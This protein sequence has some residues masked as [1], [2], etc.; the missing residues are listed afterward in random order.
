LQKLASARKGNSISLVEGESDC[1]TLWSCGFPALGLPGAGNW[2]DD[3][4]APLLGDFDV[5]YLLIEPDDGGRRALAWLS[6]SRIRDRVRLVWLDGFKD[7][8]A[9]Y[10]DNPPVFAA[11]WQ[12]ALDAAEPFSEI[13]DRKAAD[14]AKESLNKAL[15]QG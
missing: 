4:D 7:A 12:A 8:S 15:I 6:R 2:N 14:D 11:Q 5:I 13:A 3:R 10:C 9:L 1:Q